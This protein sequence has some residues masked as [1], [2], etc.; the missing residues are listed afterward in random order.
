MTFRA[1]AFSSR[2]AAAIAGAAYLITSAT[3]FLFVAAAFEAVRGL[4]TVAPVSLAVIALP[5][6]L[7]EVTVGLWL[8]MKGVR[9]PEHA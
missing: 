7:F 2:Q 6:L 8:L 4:P 5:F 9:I 3:S 1:H